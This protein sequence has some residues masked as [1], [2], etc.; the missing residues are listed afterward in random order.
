MTVTGDGS[1]IVTA[2]AFCERTDS[3][4]AGSTDQRGREENEEQ[5]AFHFAT[6]VISEYKIK[7]R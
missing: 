1:S 3:I 7:Q 2:L 5:S 6:H 4:F